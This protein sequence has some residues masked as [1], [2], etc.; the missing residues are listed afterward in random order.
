MSW[1]NC[2]FSSETNHALFYFAY[3]QAT[4]LFSRTVFNKYVLLGQNVK[5]ITNEVSDVTEHAC[6][7]CQQSAL[8]EQITLAAV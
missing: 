7:P 8:L 4:L 6:I 3:Q 1:S 2:Y 5:S